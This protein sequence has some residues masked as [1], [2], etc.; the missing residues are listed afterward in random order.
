MCF[1]LD[2]TC[3]RAISFQD[4]T[5]NLNSSFLNLDHLLRVLDS[6]LLLS[7]LLRRF[8]S[9]LLVVRAYKSEI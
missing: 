1:I 8:G 4:V 9:I 3:A 6:F 2:F 5:E 7:P